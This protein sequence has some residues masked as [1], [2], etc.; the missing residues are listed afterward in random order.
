ML[1][2]DESRVRRAS[3][4]YTTGVARPVPTADQGA[5][6]EAGRIRN[7]FAQV[8]PRYDLLNHL[9]SAS[10]DRLWRRR[11]AEALAGAGDGLPV[12]DLCCGTGDQAL[13]LARR[14][15]RVVASDFC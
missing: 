13:A 3:E 4:G 10:L 5:D 8:A 6:Q 14:S 1:R 7:M 11:A 2:R 15:H 9:L 12:L